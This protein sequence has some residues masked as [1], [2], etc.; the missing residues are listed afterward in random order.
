MIY[1]SQPKIIHIINY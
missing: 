1:L